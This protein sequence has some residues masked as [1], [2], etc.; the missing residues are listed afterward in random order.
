MDTFYPHYKISCLMLCR[1]TKAT[2][3]KSDTKHRQCT[4]YHRAWNGL[5]HNIPS[6]HSLPQGL[7]RFKSQYSFP[8]FLHINY[9]VTFV[10]FSVTVESLLSLSDASTAM[11]LSPG[12]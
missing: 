5:S 8:V 11:S 10:E 4:I 2:S 6:I 9:V 1:E 3:F 7:K 12:N